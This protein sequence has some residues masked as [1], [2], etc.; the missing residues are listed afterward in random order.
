M[1]GRVIRITRES[2][3]LTGNA[4]VLVTYKN[5]LSG[6]QRIPLSD[7]ITTNGAVIITAMGNTWLQLTQ[8]FPNKLGIRITEKPQY[9]TF[10][11]P[12]KNSTIKKKICGLTYITLNTFKLDQRKMISY[13]R[14]LMWY[15]IV[16]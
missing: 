7:S 8:N 9:C 3:P 14:K 15:D 16:K 5:Y 2:G 4:L 1:G 10:R 12:D 6:L 13:I 11:K